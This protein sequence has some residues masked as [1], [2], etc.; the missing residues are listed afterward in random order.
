[1]VSLSINNTFEGTPL[2][3]VAFERHRG[4]SVVSQFARNA[5]IDTTTDPEDLW[6]S[7]GLFTGQT[8]DDEA[9]EVL[10]SSAADAAAGTG[11]RTVEISG[12]DSNFALQSETVTLNG[13]TPVDTAGTYTR[14]HSVR[15][16]TAGSGGE[17]AGTITARHTTTT[18]NV[19]SVIPIGE[20]RSGIAAYT[21]PANYQGWLTHIDADVAV[22][23]AAAGWARIQLLVRPSG[24]VFEVLDQWQVADG[25]RLQ[26]EFAMP[27]KIAAQ[28]DVRIRIDQVSTDNTS[29]SG[30]F[31][32]ILQE[33]GVG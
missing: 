20:N 13:T 9:V 30:G 11:A 12:L 16:L 27:H 31:E 23:A 3:Q 18:A 26:R 33:L 32:M 15:V 7:S 10:S 24:G 25:E 29:V 1:M 4:I 17:N 22:A 2:Q 21:V 6:N 5:D 14:V 19:F 8:T 28:S